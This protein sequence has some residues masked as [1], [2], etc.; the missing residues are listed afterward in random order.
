MTIATG[1]SET[2]TALGV[3][4]W[5]RMYRQMLRIRLFEEQVNESVQARA[6]AGARAPILGRRGR[7]C[8]DLRGAAGR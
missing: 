1:S 6:D 5:M 4:Q 8:G 7:G 2:Q 3:Q